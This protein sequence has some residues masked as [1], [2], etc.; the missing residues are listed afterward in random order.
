MPKNRF[1]T[2]MQ[3]ASE[4]YS[5]PAIS[6]LSPEELATALLIRDRLLS[7]VPRKF[8]AEDFLSAFGKILGQA[9][10]KI[11]N[12]A[13]IIQTLHSEYAGVG[14]FWTEEAGTTTYVV[15]HEED[16]LLT[17]ESTPLNFVNRT[18]EWL[19]LDL[20]D[21]EL[22]KFPVLQKFKEEGYHRC[23]FVPLSY[24]DETRNAIGF[25]SKDPE[26]FGPS[27]LAIIDAILPTLT[28]TLE[29]LIANYKIHTML[30]TYVGSEPKQEILSGTVRRGQVTRI[31]SAILF[32][33]MRDYTRIAAVQ[34]PEE[35]VDLLDTY[36][37]CVVPCVEQNGGEVLK[38]I[39]DGI[40]AIFRD[41]AD[42]T[43]SAAYSALKAATRSLQMIEQANQSGR[44]KQPVSIGIA[45]HHGEAAYGNVGSG[46][47]LDFTVIGPDVNLASRIARMNRDLHEPLLTSKP[48]AEQLW[49]DLERIGSYPVPGLTDPIDIYRP[50]KN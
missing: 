33:D 46:S 8:P 35:T 25:A 21:P 26:S 29:V 1:R 24:A 3:E 14:R 11:D 16:E 49:F 20:D 22:E 13:A 41:Y 42:D 30:S 18:G 27:V 7:E 38:Y 31:R 17:D 4:N 39:G 10:L 28:L 19:L 32:A 12:V 34:S 40:L 2:C 5:V 43:G 9:G 47:R 23:L 6:S 37:D 48:F 45:L 15:R 44:F 50:S 36:F